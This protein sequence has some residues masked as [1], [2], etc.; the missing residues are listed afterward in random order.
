MNC[1]LYT[2]Q[3]FLGICIVISWTPSSNASDLW[4]DVLGIDLVKGTVSKKCL[5]KFIS[6]YIPTTQTMQFLQP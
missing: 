6:D 2:T 1:R 5:R 4:N 3:K